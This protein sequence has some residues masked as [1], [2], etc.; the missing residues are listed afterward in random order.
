M[1]KA[2][3]KE[4]ALS[5][6]IELKNVTKV[7]KTSDEPYVALKGVSFTVERGEIVA[8]IGASGSGKTTTMNLLGLLD[9][10]TSGK[11]YL[12][13]LDTSLFS[14]E[15]LA[16]LRNEKIG[17]IFQS[18]FLLP[19]L[20]ALQNVMLPLSYRRHHPASDRR[21]KNRARAMLAKVG[22]AKYVAHKPYELSGGQQQRVAIA[23][24]LVGDPSIIL[25][26]EPTGALDSKNSRD[27]LELLFELN[28]T[29]G[30]TI[31]II[32]HDPEVAKH[33]KRVIK[34]ADGLIWDS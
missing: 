7:Y 30:A 26:D 22:M 12:D 13:G 11:Y 32:T 8:L 18:F 4:I 9:H 10:P 20:T 34:I 16:D 23:R 19:R 15:K 29:E 27:V 25:A 31:V 6:L 2:Y 14:L 33:A 17:F 28:T 24:A 21:D 5:S 3:L 1:Y